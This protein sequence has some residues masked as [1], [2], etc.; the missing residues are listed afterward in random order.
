MPEI[1]KSVPAWLEQ[2][3]NKWRRFELTS[4]NKAQVDELN[5]ILTRHNLSRRE[6]AVI[7][8]TLQLRPEFTL[9]DFRAEQDLPALSDRER[10]IQALLDFTEQTVKGNGLLESNVKALPSVAAI[11]AGLLA[12]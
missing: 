8:E 6:L 5:A 10:L 1:E 4:E 11:L 3:R 12:E 9:D 2:E 7:T